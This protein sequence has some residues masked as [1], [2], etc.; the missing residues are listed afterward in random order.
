M[1]LVLMIFGMYCI[2][3]NNRAFGLFLFVL[4]CMNL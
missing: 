1:G 3:N 2:S 4:G